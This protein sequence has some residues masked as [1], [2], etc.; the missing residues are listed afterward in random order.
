[1]TNTT[2]FEIP[3]AAP[4]IAQLYNQP[5]RHALS[6]L[7]AFS[8][9]AFVGLL[10]SIF[11]HSPW[12]AERA[13]EGRPFPSIAA[14]H[15]AM[16]DTVKAAG[17]E[18]QLTLIRAH[19]DLVGNAVL[20]AESAREQAAAGLANLDPAE[21]ELFAR[22]NKEYKTR[23]DFPFVICARLNKKKAI[24]EAFPRRLKND[25]GEERAAALE[26]IYKIAQLRL[27]DLIAA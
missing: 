5:M 11:E 4:G 7:N 8:A 9:E 22:Y 15:A 25:A 2:G 21:V 14:L 19:P 10:G 3:V 1:M 27:D 24:L 6:D 12:V 20:S 26:E 13:A 17:E 16:S 18:K 23:F